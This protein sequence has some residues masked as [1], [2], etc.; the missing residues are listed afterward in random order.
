LFYRTACLL[1][2]YN[3]NVTYIDY[4]DGVIS[5][6]IKKG[7][8]NIRLIE[9]E[10]GSNVEIDGGCTVFSPASYMGILFHIFPNVRK[11]EVIFW[12]LSPVNNPVHQIVSR[13]GENAYVRRMVSRLFNHAIKDSADRIIFLSKSGN[14]FF[15]DQG[16][17]DYLSNEFGIDIDRINFLPIFLPNLLDNRNVHSQGCRE[18]YFWL[19]RIDTSLKFYI[20][21][22]I[23]KD[24]HKY[25][26]ISGTGDFFLICS[27]DG[28]IR[29]RKYVDKNLNAEYIHFLGR[30]ENN[31][32]GEALCKASVVFAH[33]TAALEAAARGHFVCIAESFYTEVPDCYK[34]IPFSSGDS[35]FV[36]RVVSGSYHAPKM[37]L[38]FG[39]I[40]MAVN[41]GEAEKY[42]QRSLRKY[43][44]YFSEDAFRS[45][46]EKAMS[47][48][49]PVELARLRSPLD[50][51]FYKVR[52]WL[53]PTNK[54]I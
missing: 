27:G 25:R 41:N 21:K 24:F 53:K 28:L 34:Y 11:V 2:K 46:L 33:G 45:N 32:L 13:I 23:L 50:Y 40:A 9:Y 29:L 7:N 26:N 19:G 54:I 51:V 5:Q 52:G 47:I 31:S 10:S 30:V 1:A 22:K 35:Y 16:Q 12:Y 8:E 14:L 42:A 20:V 18:N 15:M 44:E 48:A 17:V 38:T 6:M 39:E 4:A 3:N 43:K 36:G 37:A 49:T